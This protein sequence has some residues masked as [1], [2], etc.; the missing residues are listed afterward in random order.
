MVLE[1]V[2]DVLLG[3][4]I[5]P[6]FQTQSDEFLEHLLLLEEAYLLGFLA[7]SFAVKPHKFVKEVLANLCQRLCHV[8]FAP[9][10]RVH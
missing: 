9:K 7:V 1:K 6:F 3:V 4:E 5:E 8:Y 10:L 2:V